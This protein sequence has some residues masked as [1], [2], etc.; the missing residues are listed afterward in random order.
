M[1]NKQSMG[2]IITR[3]KKIFKDSSGIVN[4]IVLKDVYMDLEDGEENIEVIKQFGDGKLVPVLVDIRESFEITKA[5]R[6]Y[7]GGSYSSTVM[8][9]VALIID[10]PLS[11]L[12]GNFMLGLNKPLFPLK[13]FKNKTEAKKW[14]KTFL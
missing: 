13:L 7:Y 2:E 5:C 11:R 14:L 8:S 4:C 3:T 9:A 12:L 6:N 1:I 10:S